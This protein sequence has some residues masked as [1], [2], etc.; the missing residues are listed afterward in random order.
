MKNAGS[1]LRLRRLSWKQRTFKVRVAFLR[2][3]TT[4]ERNGC[5]PCSFLALRKTVEL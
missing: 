5:I 3:D 1:E 4:D 2:P